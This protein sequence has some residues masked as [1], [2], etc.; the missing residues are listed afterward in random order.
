MKDFLIRR[1]VYEWM[2]EF[3]KPEAD[4]EKLQHIESILE[5]MDPLKADG[6]L[7]K[8][9]FY[10]EHIK[11]RQVLKSSRRKRYLSVAVKA[12]VFVLVFIISAQAI[13]YAITGKSIFRYLGQMKEETSMIEVEIHDTGEVSVHDLLEELM[14]YLGSIQDGKAGE[15]KDKYVSSW[16]EIEEMSNGK[17]MYPR[18]IPKGW[19]LDELR[20]QVLGTS[21][22]ATLATYKKGEKSTYY[23]F[24][25]YSG[26]GD[27]G[28]RIYF[29]EKRKRIKVIK[30]A[31]GEFYVYKGK[32]ATSVLGYVSTYQINISSDNTVDEIESLIKSIK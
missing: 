8:A 7:E 25:D 15:Y 19:K 2:L 18:Q 21:L 31:G 17:V 3:L 4:Q 28:E 29:G 23:V 24:E 9:A 26:K 6:R 30:H 1:W 14:N 16:D 11:R 10:S 22:G 27:G 32:E 20:V 5:C 13:C 12:A